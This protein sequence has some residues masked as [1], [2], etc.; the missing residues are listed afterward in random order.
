M[1]LSFQ[2]FHLLKL[3]P[4]VLLTYGLCFQEFHLPQLSPLVLLFYGLV[5][6]RISPSR[7]ISLC[8]TYLWTGPSKNFTFPEYLPLL[9]SF[10]EF[11]L[12]EKPPLVLLAYGLSFQEFHL[13]MLP[14]PPPHPPCSTSLTY[15]LS[16]PSNLPLFY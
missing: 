12:P 2:R 4:H 8:S 6:P 1:D 7:V 5:H 16:F 14:P 13:P 15:R 3:P 10:Q 11:Y 9:L